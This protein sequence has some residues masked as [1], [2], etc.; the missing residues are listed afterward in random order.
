MPYWWSHRSEMRKAKD[1]LEQAQVSFKELGFTG[2]KWKP[3]TKFS[4]LNNNFGCRLYFIVWTARGVLGHG[5]LVIWR[6]NCEMRER[7]DVTRDPAKPLP[8]RAA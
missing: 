8:T 4:P 6:A 2:T 5:F 1:E 7:S 3:T